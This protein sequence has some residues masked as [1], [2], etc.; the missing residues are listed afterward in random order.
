M[1]N[2][3]DM[4]CAIAFLCNVW[5]VWAG[6]LYLCD[7]IIHQQQMFDRAVVLELGAGVGLASIVASMFAERIFT[8]GFIFS[9]CIMKQINHWHNIQVKL[10][11]FNL[12]HAHAN[13]L[14]ARC[15]F[16]H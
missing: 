1:P 4:F 6:C 14:L 8:T 15:H 5:Q 12:L 11:K 10:G 3:N 2:A 16:V 9:E 7:F 13:P